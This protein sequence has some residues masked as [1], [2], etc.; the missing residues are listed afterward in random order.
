M[1]SPAAPWAGRLLLVVA[2]AFILYVTLN[3]LRTEGPGSAGLE[4]GGAM[5]PFAAP[6]ARSSLEGDVNIATEE[7]AGGP[8]GQRPACD[9]RGPDVL[10]ACALWEQRPVALAF[11]ATR[12]TKCTGALDQLERLRPRFPG[13]AMAA[14]AVR[15]D[16][17]D[18]RRL[19][20]ERGWDLPVAYDRDGVLANLYGVAVCPHLVL[21]RRG[22][23]V[24]RTLVG[25]VTD[26]ELA[27]RLE[28]LA[29]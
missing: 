9:V 25:T 10:N 15:G 3:G 18:I 16:R 20:R 13:V 22:G 24:D 28:A 4:G 26:A 19:A 5:P 11:V 2:V 21:A 8:A 23:E 29:P 27:R 14:V 1:S 6:L 12:G 7:T 17:D